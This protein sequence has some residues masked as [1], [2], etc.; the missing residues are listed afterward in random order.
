MSLSRL[1]NLSHTEPRNPVLWFFFSFFLFLGMLFS[2]DYTLI[3]PRRVGLSVV[4]P[5]RKWANISAWYGVEREREGERLCEW[6]LCVGCA[7]DLLGNTKIMQKYD[8]DTFYCND[9]NILY[10]D[11][12]KLV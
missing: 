4:R 9:N 7:W 10:R 2:I 8:I 5:E 11:Y 6:Q 1:R 3:G 12:G